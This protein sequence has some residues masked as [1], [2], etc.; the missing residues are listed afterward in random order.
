MSNQRQGHETVWTIFALV[1]HSHRENANQENIY[2]ANRHYTL[3]P[4][5][6]TY[7]FLG[8]SGFRARNVG[9]GFQMLEPEKY[10]ADYGAELVQSSFKAYFRTGQ[11]LCFLCS[12]FLIPRECCI[13]SY[14]MQM[15]PKK[16][17]YLLE[18]EKWCS[19]IFDSSF[20]AKRL[21]YI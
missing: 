14:I 8:T 2:T 10:P 12:F 21:I 11:F 20:T 18:S 13:F 9:T 6:F 7:A 4:I 5:L 1:H 16:P 15:P 17:L 3:K 19:S